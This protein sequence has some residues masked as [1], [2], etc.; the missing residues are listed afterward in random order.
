MPRVNGSYRILSLDG[1]GSWAI[2]EVIAL[3]ALWKA[4]NV[5][6]PVGYPDPDPRGWAVLREFDLVAANSGGNFVLAALAC[7]WRLS[8]LYKALADPSASQRSTMFVPLSA[9]QKLAYASNWIF[10]LL[11]KSGPRYDAA[12]KLSGI[13]AVYGNPP[14][15]FLGPLGVPNDPLLPHADADTALDAL[16]ARISAVNGVNTN[17]LITTFD[18]DRERAQFFRS[19]TDSAASGL[20]PSAVPTLAEAVH[21]SS[22]APIFYFN[23]PAQ[24]N[25]PAANPAFAACRFWDGAVSGYNNPVLAAVVE[26][27]ANAGATPFNTLNVLSIGT[28]KVYL[29]LPDDPSRVAQGVADDP[30]MVP[31]RQSDGSLSS[32]EELATSIGDDPPD[33]ASF[34]ALTLGR[35]AAPVAQGISKW[36]IG[37]GSL[38]R[39]NPLILDSAVKLEDCHGTCC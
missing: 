3:Q 6:D 23:L 18:F 33:A 35:L 36:A 1:G 39:M 21:A 11:G 2:I 8:D 27:V 22:N 5:Q 26:A 13:R 38:V 28:G 34:I 19:N 14:P 7:N 20:P 31:P 9:L 15:A 4:L 12:K 25:D 17:F 29:P 32:I 37:N 10:S 24:F 16:A 30:T